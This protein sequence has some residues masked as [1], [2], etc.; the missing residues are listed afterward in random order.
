[1]MEIRHRATHEFDAM[2]L[3]GRSPGTL[4]LRNHHFHYH[5]NIVSIWPVNVAADRYLLPRTNLLR[6]FDFVHL[7]RFRLQHIIQ[8]GPYH[9]LR[10]L[11]AQR[12][13][14]LRFRVQ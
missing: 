5:N 7:D 12:L 11:L 8:I 2:P 6:Q 10:P 3:A 13:H 1:M 14:D 9:P 4:A